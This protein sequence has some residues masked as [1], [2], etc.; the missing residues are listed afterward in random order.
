MEEILSTDPG[1]C[2]L[3][4]LSKMTFHYTSALETE[5]P[6]NIAHTP[7]T[8]VGTIGETTST[9]TTTTTTAEGTNMSMSEQGNDQRRGDILPIVYDVQS[10]PTIGSGIST[11]I[12][13]GGPGR[14]QRPWISSMFLLPISNKGENSIF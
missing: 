4:S 13:R 11:Q 8:I 1:N 9:S 14:P 7:S 12:N 10:I 2:R 3:Y 6:S 5:P